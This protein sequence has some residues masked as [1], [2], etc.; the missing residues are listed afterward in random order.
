MTL[1]DF[2]QSNQEQEDG[3][4]HCFDMSAF[5]ANGS[6]SLELVG[7]ALNGPSPLT[8]SSSSSPIRDR[9]TD[10]S[11]RIDNIESRFTDLEMRI[12]DINSRV[13]G[14]EAGAIPDIMARLENI[15]ERLNLTGVIPDVMA[16]LE[17]INDRLNLL[18]GRR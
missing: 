8:F 4:V 15:N 2:F 1:T 3:K 16:R 5:N 9:F 14:I 10:L 6:T 7:S 17:I 11:M 13:T 12:D 18:E